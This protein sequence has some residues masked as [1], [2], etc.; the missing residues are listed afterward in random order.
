MLRQRPGVVIA[1]GGPDVVLV[2]VV[3][4]NAAVADVEIVDVVIL[5]GPV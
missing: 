1:D 4:T 2:D 5:G 3:T